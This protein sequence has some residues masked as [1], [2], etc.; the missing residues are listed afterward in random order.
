MGKDVQ[1]QFLWIWISAHLAPLS[2]LDLPTVSS[3]DFYHRLEC[4]HDPE[5]KDISTRTS[6]HGPLNGSSFIALSI[7]SLSTLLDITRM[8]KKVIAQKK[9]SCSNIIIF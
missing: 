9:S 2:Y 6:S 1:K 7:P 4:V 3:F 5:A 8:I